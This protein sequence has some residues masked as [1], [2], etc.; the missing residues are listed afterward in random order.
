MV[1]I[2]LTGRE[3]RRSFNI[4]QHR[5]PFAGSVPFI[6]LEGADGRSYAVNRREV[7]TWTFRDSPKVSVE[8]T[9]AVRLLRVGQTAWVE[10][11]A[12][13]SVWPNEDMGS[14]NYVFELIDTDVEPDQALSLIAAAQSRIFFYCG[15]SWRFCPL[16][17][18]PLVRAVTLE[19]AESI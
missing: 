18:G 5:Q 11:E 3:Y 6:V 17:L 9:T 19:H 8:A 7:Q 10:F 2:P 1:A 12:S 4:L 15:G 13:D 16:Q 14:L